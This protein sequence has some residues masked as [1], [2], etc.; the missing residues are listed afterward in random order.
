M[1][2]DVY[3]HSREHFRMDICALQKFLFHSSSPMM[4]DYGV[5][6]FSDQ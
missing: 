4:H 5:M 6:L 3:P 1:H 2:L